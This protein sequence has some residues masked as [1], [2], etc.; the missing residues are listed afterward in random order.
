MRGGLIGAALLVALVS[1]ALFLAGISGVRWY[2]SPDNELSIVQRR[3]LVQGLASRGQAFA[4]FLTGAV[5]LIGLFFTWQNTSQA[6]KSTQKTLELV[7]QGQ[8]TERFTQTID[9]LGKTDE[10]GEKV[11]E[12]RMGAIYALERIARESEVDHESIME[13]LTAYVRLH[14][15]RT[16]EAKDINE[17]NESESVQ[18]THADPDIQAIL[19]IIGRRSQ[20][21]VEKEQRRRNLERT[22]LRHGYFYGANLRDVWFHEADLRGSLF[23]EAELQGTYFVGADLRDAFFGE[24]R[25]HG[26]G[27]AKN[28]KGTN[29]RGAN[30]EGTSFTGVNLEEVIGL[31]QTQIDQAMGDENTRLPNGIQIP[32]HWVEALES[33]TNEE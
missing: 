24:S 30:L 6:R 31:T 8:I 20:E 7:E 32:D 22:D 10:H 16:E 26:V 2:L 17:V 25:Q 28:L 33:E 1:I 13:I 12:T 3:D 14:S 21:R 18:V 4:V 9:Q 27:G 5:G 19:D 23:A 15:P 11:L 29:F